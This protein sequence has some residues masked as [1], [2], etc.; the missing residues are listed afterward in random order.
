MFHKGKRRRRFIELVST[1]PDAASSDGLLEL[2]RVAA[3]FEPARYE[4]LNEHPPEASDDRDEPQRFTPA[5]VPARTRTV[6]ETST[7]EKIFHFGCYPSATR[8]YF[9]QKR[10]TPAASHPEAIHPK[11]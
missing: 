4:L 3:I 7:G 6:S 2:S 11:D 10:A 1:A 9:D 8:F 5:S